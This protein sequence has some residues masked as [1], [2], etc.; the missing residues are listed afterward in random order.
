M[1]IKFLLFTILACQMA[2]AQVLV[3]PC[4][5]LPGCQSSVR[6]GVV[7]S[8]FSILTA[9]QKYNLLVGAGDTL[10]QQIDTTFSGSV[11]LTL[12]SGPGTFVGPAN[13]SFSKYTFMDMKFF[14]AGDYQLEIDIPGVG[15]DTMLFSV[16]VDDYAK[17]CNDYP[18]GCVSGGGTKIH[19]QG[20]NVIVVD[21]MFPFNV[22]V[23][24]PDGKIDNTYAGVVT[25]TKISG[26][27][28][29]LGNL[30]LYGE[31]RISFNDLSFDQAGTYEVKVDVE[32]IGSDT[33][34]FVVTLSNGIHEAGLEPVM[35][36][37]NP[38]S[39]N[40]SFYNKGESIFISQIDVLNILGEKVE[41]IS[42]NRL[43]QSRE[44]FQLDLNQLNSGTYYMVIQSFDKRFSSSL[45]LIK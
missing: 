25:L 20:P 19:L 31:K 16:Y 26:S 36:F 29:L 7:H 44:I 15:K 17:M 12:I 6:N 24:T 40:A 39:G 28:N 18:K 35:I 4:L 23:L 8:N 32:N 33:V 27:G 42:V 2:I 3:N 5:G 30:S 1:R 34:N 11:N 9:N 38:S 21:V 22:M 41:T 13:K 10:A 43:V 14:N 45:I 37:P